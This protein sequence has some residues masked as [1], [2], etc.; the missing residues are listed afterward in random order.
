[1]IQKEPLVSI[2][3]PAYNSQETLVNCL[4]SVIEQTYG[5]LEIIL[6]NDGSRD[7]TFRIVDDYAKKDSRIVSI[8][9]SQNE[10]LVLARKTGVEQAH[11]KYIQYL[12]ADDTL[13]EEAI[14]HLVKKAEETQADMV[15]APFLFVIEGKPEKS[16]SLDFKETTGVEFLRAILNLQAHWCVWSKFHLRSLYNE[17]IDRPDASFGEDVILSTQLLLRAKKIVSIEYEIIRYNFTPQS[18]SH[19][20]MF[21]ERKYADFKTYVNWFFSF[22]AKE[23]LSESLRKELALF[24]LKNTMSQM[25][26]KKFADFQIEIKEVLRNLKLYPDLILMIS[27]RERKIVKVYQLSLWL[28]F[29]NLKRYHL[30]GKI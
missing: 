26:W 20:Q 3:I 14:A 11:G 18:M 21:D 5:N 29:L 27:R 6:I 8:S 22:M 10:G 25:H 7:D 2:I 28:G 9:K 17:P 15:V 30:Q 19:P 23:K 1:M 12:D 4:S 24:H 13:C 16:L